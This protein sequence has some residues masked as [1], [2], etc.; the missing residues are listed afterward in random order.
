MVKRIK[1]IKG[2][3]AE[4]A[5]HEAG[6]AVVARVL[7]IGITHATMLPNA[8]ENGMTKKSQ[9]VGPDNSA[10]K[11]KIMT[12]PKPPGRAA[13]GHPAGAGVLSEFVK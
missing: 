3:K 12:R 13:S 10:R 8:E 11:R 9:T 4:I 1:E 5:Y 2:R 6:H 7:G